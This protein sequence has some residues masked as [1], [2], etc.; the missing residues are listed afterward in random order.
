M[1]WDLNLHTGGPQS[2]ALA[3]FRPKRALR[4]GAMTMLFVNTNYNYYCKIL[5]KILYK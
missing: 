2:S 3:D 1:F 4:T 5:Q